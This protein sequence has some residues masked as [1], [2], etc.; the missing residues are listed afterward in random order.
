MRSADHKN[1][2][3]TPYV[4][5]S[6]VYK[7]EIVMKKCSRCEQD[8]H[9]TEFPVRRAAHD[10]RAAACKTC[11]NDAKS[12]AYWVNTGERQ[13][14]IERTVRTKKARFEADPAYHRAF[15]LWTST[16]RRTKI[17]AWVKIMDFHE[18]CKL[19]VKKG[20]G[21]VIDHIV[22][23]SHPDVCGLHVPWNVRVVTKKKN[24]DKGSKFKSDW[25]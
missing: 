13:K 5:E 20:P 6:E 21:H 7:P 3:K 4:I 2:Q 10:G 12:T 8:K 15:N 25:G 24:T 16:R 22:P 11:I 9:L 1:F 17:P 18:V 23:I 14:S 19:A